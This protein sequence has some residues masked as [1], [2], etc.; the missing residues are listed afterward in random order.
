MCGWFAVCANIAFA[1]DGE[2]DLRRTAGPESALVIEVSGLP[3]LYTGVRASRWFE[4][5]TESALFRRWRGSAGFAGL[6]RTVNEVEGHLGEPLPKVVEGLAR[7]GV[8]CVLEP[9]SEGV[10]PGWVLAGHGVSAERVAELVA[11]WNRLEQARTETRTAEGFSWTERQAG[12]ASDAPLVYVVRGARWWLSNREHLLRGAVTRCTAETVP[13]AAEA[14]FDWSREFD[15]LPKNAHVRA[16][17]RARAWDDM[18]KVDEALVSDNAGDKFTAQWW[19]GTDALSCSLAFDAEGAE[20]GPDIEL[21]ASWSEASPRWLAVCESSQGGTPFLERVP[22]NALVTV[23]GRLQPLAGWNW[24]PIPDDEHA[25]RDLGRLRS[26]VMGLCFGMDPFDDILAGLEANWGLA[27]VPLDGD[28]PGRW[29]LAVVA[30]CELPGEGRTDWDA[31]R[32][33]L[34][35]RGLANAVRT[36]LTIWSVSINEKR[37]GRP[38]RLRV[39]PALEGSA[40][41]E[42]VWLDGLD[43][44]EPCYSVGDR[45]FALGTSPVPLRSL[46]ESSSSNTG[47]RGGDTFPRDDAVRQNV[48]AHVAVKRLRD[49]LVDQKAA[50]AEAIARSQK[51][52]AQ[53]VERRLERLSEGLELADDLVLGARFEEREIMLRGTWTASDK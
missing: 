51:L 39:E 21:R 33:S 44:A 7:N 35:R 3:S 1:A 17:A 24:L 43:E 31:S 19:R 16:V 8:V 30:L 18:L 41:P 52:D 50:L 28:V 49:W 23:A 36:G 48:L 9:A 53:G 11:L 14:K 5:V 26:V 42:L 40:A 4:R 27:V 38:T 20:Q 12:Q 37:D 32:R 25:R 15:R 46:L 2:V 29:P 10:V 13:V 34:L 22:A 6:V 45:F 47:W